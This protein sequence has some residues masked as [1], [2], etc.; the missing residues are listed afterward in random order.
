MNVSE[1]VCERASQVIRKQRS[2]PDVTYGCVSMWFIFL[3]ACA[4]LRV[5]VRACVRERASQGIRKQWSM[6]D[7]KCGCESMWFIF[8]IGMCVSECACMCVC[9]TQEAL[10][11]SSASQT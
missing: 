1:C 2:T 10:R 3:C 5:C 6:P 8:F 4:C 9:M 7:I 11:N